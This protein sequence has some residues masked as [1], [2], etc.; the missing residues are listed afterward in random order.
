MLVVH[1]QYYAEGPEVWGDRV[2]ALD[3]LLFTGRFH[4]LFAFLFGVGFAMQVERSGDR[5]GFAWIYTRRLLALAVFALLIVAFTDYRVLLDY[6][7][8]GFGLLLIRR[9]SSRAL[10]VLAICC[11]LMPATV[12]GLR[13]Q[14]ESRTIGL[15][16][17]NAAVRHEGQRWS[18]YQR[19]E[20]ELRARGDFGALVVN[21][22]RFEGSGFLRWQRYLPGATML[23]F[24]LGL[25]AVR[26]GVL[27]QPDMHRRL[28]WTVLVAGA[29]LGLASNA[30]N[31]SAWLSGESLRLR[32]TWNALQWAILSERFQ[33]L[34]YAAAILLWISR[35]STF[36]RPAALLALAGR[37][38]LTNYVVQICFLELVF[39]FGGVKIT[40]PTALLAT[41]VVFTV[42]IAYSGWWLQRFR[43]GPLEWLWRSVTYW[44]VEPLRVQPPVDVV[45]V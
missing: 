1:F 23:L 11:L 38:S 41:A 32:N 7:F 24:A 31:I 34:A 8:W 43:M 10:V 36:P 3:T 29:L 39:A 19:E 16:A 28:L 21:R 17:S 42:Q 5:P 40:R 6:A 12:S 30:P 18:T 44:R 35:G 33:G 27:R 22:L 25:L 2:E 20:R 37:M 9:W 26:T 4:A 14:I 13:W 45:A 15:E